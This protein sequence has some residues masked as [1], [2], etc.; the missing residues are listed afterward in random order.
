MICRFGFRASLSAMGLLVSTTFA[1]AEDARD[2]SGKVGDTATIADGV[3]Q[4]EVPRSSAIIG[5]VDKS[6]KGMTF[7]SAIGRGDIG[8]AVAEIATWRNQATVV[9]K[10]AG[11]CARSTPGTYTRIAAA[12]ICGTTA[13]SLYNKHI[14]EPAAHAINSAIA[15]SVERNGER[16]NGLP[17]VS[18]TNPKVSREGTIVGPDLEDVEMFT[19]E[20][21]A[22]FQDPPERNFDHGEVDQACID[23]YPEVGFMEL[24][25][26][27]K[28]CAS[29]DAS[30]VCE[31]TEKLAGT[32]NNEADIPQWA[33]DQKWS[34]DEYNDYLREQVEW[35]RDALSRSIEGL[36]AAKVRNDAYI[37]NCNKNAQCKSVLHIQMRSINKQAERLE[38][39]EKEYMSK[40][41]E[42]YEGN[43][44]AFR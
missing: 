29:F 1:E 41:C 7:G 10:A 37:E 34:L 23:E 18:E 24:G 33:V 22:G 35:Q 8:T 12:G 16:L 19:N 42:R 5:V 3:V 44:A 40:F 11:R 9:V 15:R 20:N 27:Q 36:R 30:S 43:Q 4:A 28:F 6:A 39:A 21:P 32:I 17:I 25:E 14:K 38:N 13:N 31:G 26:R 2:V